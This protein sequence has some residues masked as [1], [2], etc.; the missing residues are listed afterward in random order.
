MRCTRGQGVGDGL[1]Q[2]R[3]PYA[4][5]VGGLAAVDDERR[6][7]PQAAN[8]TMPVRTSIDERPQTNLGGSTRFG[9]GGPYRTTEILGHHDLGS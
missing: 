9:Y 4:K 5:S 6:A 2:G 7:Q 8:A 1:T 3:W